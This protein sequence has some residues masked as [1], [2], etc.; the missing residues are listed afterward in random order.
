MTR[1]HGLAVARA[2]WPSGALAREGVG[3]GTEDTVWAG[4][5][6]LRSHFGFT[7]TDP[8][9]TGAKLHQLESD[10]R[11]DPMLEST[12]VSP[13]WFAQSGPASSP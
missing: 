9:A 10:D 13:L 5:E 12:S 2:G 1:H 8:G 7:G 3:A 6:R 11:A 4:R